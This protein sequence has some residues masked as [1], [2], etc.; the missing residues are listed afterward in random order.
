MGMHAILGVVREQAVSNKTAG[1]D[2]RRARSSSLAEVCLVTAEA[3][4]AALELAG[5]DAERRYLS[6]RLAETGGEA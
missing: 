5:T 2:S 1:A 6:R 4:A 3:Y